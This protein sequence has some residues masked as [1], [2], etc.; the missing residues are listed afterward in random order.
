MKLKRLLNLFR[1]FKKGQNIK[2][3]PYE[4]SESEKIIR[5][6]FSPIN[7]NKSKTRLL[8]NAFRSPAGFDEVSVSRL[9]YTN[10][11][12]CKRHGKAIEMPEAK[13]SFY[14][15]ALLYVSQILSSESKV[16]Y[17]PKTDNIYHADI[18]IGFIPEKGQQLPPEFQ[19]KVKK[20]TEKS[21]LYIDNNPSSNNW[22][23]KLPIE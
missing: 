4:F 3:L 19:K 1:F 6:L 15:F 16:E 12:F 23:G 9:S 20:L 8:P 21:K 11:D 22:G 18:K 2:S 17:S 13:R 10:I 14:G 5:S 7:F